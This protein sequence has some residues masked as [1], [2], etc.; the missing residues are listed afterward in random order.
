M[1]K[2]DKTIKNLKKEL[3]KLEEKKF[4]IMFFIYD[5]KGVPS[6][7][8]TYIYQTAYTLKELGYN[9]QMLHTEKDFVGVG[10]WLG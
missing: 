9:V 1:E 5:T 8:L 7:S 10:E 4:K 2:I 6:G 3:K